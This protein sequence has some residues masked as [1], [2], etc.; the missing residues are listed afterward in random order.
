[1][2]DL[3]ATV[4]EGVGAG[5]GKGLTTGVLTYFAL[6]SSLGSASHIM[7][8]PLPLDMGR[9]SSSCSTPENYR[10]EEISTWC[11]TKLDNTEELGARPSTWLCHLGVITLGKVFF[12]LFRFFAFVGYWGFELRASSLPSSHYTT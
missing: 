8:I 2:P 10:S 9:L 6:V 4:G 3:S 12:C 11:E 1:L 5:R 7:I